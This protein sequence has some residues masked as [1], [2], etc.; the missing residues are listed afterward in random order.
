[1]SESKKVIGLNVNDLL[2]TQ[3]GLRH[4]EQLNPMIKFVKDGGT[5]DESTLGSYAIR[6]GLQAV[7]PLIEVA[8]FEDGKYALHN[9]HHR[10][11]AIFLGRHHPFLFKNEYF[12]R[13][14]KYSDYTDIVLPTWVT[15][16]DV[17]TEI[18]VPELAQWKNDVRRLYI[19]AGEQR[20][21]DWI[22][23]NKSEIILQRGDM[24]H[25]EQFVVTNRL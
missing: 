12:I 8:I 16:F 9:G 1:M 22:Q 15:P 24:F 20:T 13:K 11:S 17:R 2:V 25:I 14:W 5:F 3:S 19:E 18:R 6:Y 10:V 21:I 23:A 4:L 7:A